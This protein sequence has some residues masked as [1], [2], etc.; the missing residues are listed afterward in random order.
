MLV[1]ICKGFILVYDVTKK[2]TF[3]DVDSIKE[4]V[5][6]IKKSTKK[7]PAPILLIGNKTDV[8]GREV[9][10]VSWYFVLTKLGSS[11]CRTRES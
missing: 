3:E 8:D 9:F 11:C 4:M 10:G 7:N 1:E 5:W 2:T 6:R